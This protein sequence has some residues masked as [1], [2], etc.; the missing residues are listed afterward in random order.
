LIGR[1]VP[2]F[3]DKRIREIIKENYRVI[4]QVRNETSIFILTVFHCARLLSI[5]NL[6]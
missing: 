3:N 4:Y 6:K 5:K 2:E 1:Y